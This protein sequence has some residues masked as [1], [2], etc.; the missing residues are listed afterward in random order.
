MRFD[1]PIYFQKIINGTYDED[2]GNY[3]SDTVT[4]TKK[5]ASVTNSGTDTLNLIYGELKQ[6]SLTIRIQ[7]HYDEPFDRIRINEKI[8]KV[9]MARRLLSKHIFIVSEVQ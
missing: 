3:N 2:T 5:Y 7:N 9:D 1:T 6:G 4:E 8:Y